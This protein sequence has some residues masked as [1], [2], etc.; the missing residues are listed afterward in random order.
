MSR[1]RLE[2]LTH[3]TKDDIMIEITSGQTGESANV[4]VPFREI[5]EIIEALKAALERRPLPEKGS[6]H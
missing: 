5:P 6:K 3:E 1:S 4:I 2:I